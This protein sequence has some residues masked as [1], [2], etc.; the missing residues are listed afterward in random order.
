MT[1]SVAPLRRG[2]LLVFG[3]LGTF[4]FFGCSSV[5]PDAGQEAVLIRKP[6]IFGSGG[7]VA[8]PVKAGRTYVAMTT[9]AIYIN[10][11]PQTFHLNIDDVM[12]RDGVPLDFSATI[13]LRVNDSVKMV[14]NFGSDWYPKNVEQPFFMAIRDSVKKRGM[15]EVAIDASAADAIDSEVTTVMTKYLADKSIPADLIDLTVGKANP[16]DAVKNQRIETAH[17]EQRINTEK[18]TK[19]AEDQRAMAEQSRANADNAY[20]EAMKLTPEQFL[21]LKSIEAMREVCGGGKCSF[22]TTGALPTFG[23]K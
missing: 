22:V 18:Q 10:M 6:I 16:P 12:S 19:L 14:T 13:R 4:T 9:Q 2:L 1:R 21:Q 23:I 11:Q 17:Q 5:A 15:N 20:R 8:A 7:V 3:T